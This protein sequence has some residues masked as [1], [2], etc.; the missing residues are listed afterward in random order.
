[1]LVACS[2]GRRAKRRDGVPS[3]GPPYSRGCMGLYPKP[4]PI[5]SLETLQNCYSAASAST[6]QIQ[7]LQQDIDSVG[8]TPQSQTSI[9]TTG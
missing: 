7:R 9:N 2:N 5:M 3:V 6:T 8:R 4:A 1:M